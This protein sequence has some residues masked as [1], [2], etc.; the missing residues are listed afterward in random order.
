MSK[1]E[2]FQKS[3]KASGDAFFSKLTKLIRDANERESKHQIVL[4]DKNHPPNIWDRTINTMIRGQSIPGIDLRVVG[5]IPLCKTNF[6]FKKTDSTP[7]SYLCLIQCLS[8]AL[9]RKDHPTI[10]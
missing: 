1:D 8:R 10:D 2:I 5:M 9:K 7:F 3:G 4:L 6:R